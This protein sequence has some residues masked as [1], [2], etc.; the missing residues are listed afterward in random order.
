MDNKLTEIGLDIDATF[1]PCEHPREVLKHIYT[2]NLNLP[3]REF[4]YRCLACGALVHEILTEEKE[5]VV[6]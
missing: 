5:N 3:E 6:N 2:I 1:E 4:I